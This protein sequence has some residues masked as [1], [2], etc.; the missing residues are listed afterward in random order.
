ME[1]PISDS[2]DVIYWDII[3]P[4]KKQKERKYIPLEDKVRFFLQESLIWRHRNRTNNM[5]SHKL[6]FHLLSIKQ[7]IVISL[8]CCYSIWMVY[9]DNFSCSLNRSKAN[10]LSHRKEKYSFKESL[11]VKLWRYLRSS[12]FIIM[13]WVPFQVTNL[14][15][16]Q[17]QVAL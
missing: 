2:K 9:I 16:E 15:E 12:T 1:S 6:N 4:T 5:E 13:D 17:L 7:L 11:D 14:R 8:D 10:L 3:N